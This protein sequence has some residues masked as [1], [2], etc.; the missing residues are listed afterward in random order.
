LNVL[1]TPRSFAKNDKLA[2][3]LLVQNG[4]TIIRNPTGGIMNK[5]Q[6]REYIAD[7]EGVIIGVDPLDAD[8]LSAAPKLRGIAKY[9]VGMDNI[10]LEYC[11]QHHIA[12]SKTIGANSDAVADYAFALMLSLARKLIVVDKACRQNNWNKIITSDVARKTLGLIGLGA[13]GR[14]MVNRAKGYSMKILAYD[15]CWDDAYA[16]E[17][18]ITKT[19]VDTI[20]KESDF[21]SLHLP[22]FPETR[23]TINAHRI[24]MMKPSAYLINTA[25]GGLIDDEALLTAL[26]EKRIAGAGLD[27]FAQ[28]PPE[29]KEWYSLE[30]IIIGAHCAASTSGASDNMSLMAAR[31]ILRDLGVSKGVI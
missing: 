16:E 28:E 30:N 15:V 11:K 20:C 24:G 5:D 22:L 14:Q 3:D 26:K 31:N 12:I 25:R 27:A 6:M 4:I 17:N 9:G 21:I 10:D 23:H 2:L 19:D 7:C 13:I 1:I 29:N 8:V 18:N